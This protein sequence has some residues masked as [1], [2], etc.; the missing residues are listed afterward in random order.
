MEE[1]LQEIGLTKN[2]AKI[3]LKLLEKGNCS[4]GLIAKFTGIHR[5]SVYDSLDRL[6]KKGL[7][8][9][10]KNNNKKSFEAVNPER[11]VNYVKEKEN[12]ILEVVPKLKELQNKVKEPQETTFFKGKYGLRTIFEDQLS[13]KEVLILGA[14]KVAVKLMPY[15]IHWYTKKRIEKKIKLKII[16]T[17]DQ[18]IKKV[19]LSEIRYLNE[20]YS[21]PSAINIFD[22]KVAIILWSEKNPIA[23]LIKNKEIADSYRKYFEIM[24]SIA[25]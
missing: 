1:L 20:K 12:S 23:I 21:N 22:D 19:K 25:K 9:Y 24:W 2:E 10:I 7:I 15:Y 17:K 18:D 13:S 4:A 5:R 14:S 6:I 8:G 16:T 3:Y 11:L